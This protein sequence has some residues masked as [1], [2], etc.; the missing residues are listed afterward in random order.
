VLPG[1]LN[2]DGEVNFLDINR[3]VL[4]LTDE[5]AYIAMYPNCPFGN[6]DINGDGEFDFRDI[7]RFVLLLT[8][9]A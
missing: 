5:D 4:A 8:G 7:N 1:D 9:G 6:R 2:C 3:F